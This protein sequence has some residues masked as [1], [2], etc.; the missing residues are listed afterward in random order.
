MFCAP[1]CSDCPDS[2]ATDAIP[3]RRNLLPAC[4]LGEEGRPFTAEGMHLYSVT[5]TFPGPLP[6]PDPQSEAAEFAE[7][8]LV[9]T[10]EIVGPLTCACAQQ[11][12]RFWAGRSGHAWLCYDVDDP[13]LDGAF[14]QPTAARYRNRIRAVLMQ[15]GYP[16][17]DLPDHALPRG[18]THVTSVSVALGEIRDM[19]LCTEVRVTANRCGG[20]WIAAHRAC[21]GAGGCGLT[22]HPSLAARSCGHEGFCRRHNDNT[23]PFCHCPGGCSEGEWLLRSCPN[24]CNFRGSCYKARGAC[25]RLVPRSA[26]CSL[27][28]TSPQSQCP[29]STHAYAAAQGLLH[30]HGSYAP[31]GPRPPRAC[32]CAR[33]ATGASTAPCGG[34]V[35]E[36]RGAR[37]WTSTTTSVV[38]P[39]CPRACAGRRARMPATPSA[40]RSILGRLPFTWWTS[41]RSSV[42]SRTSGS[43]GTGGRMCC[44]TPGVS[45]T[46]GRPI[47]SSSRRAW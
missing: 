1:C 4:S 23:P 31:S 17:V 16:V 28:P 12:G 42:P 27:A 32:A 21:V 10:V 24:Q 40:T 44:R 35:P 29:S 14:A 45:G 46:P 18:G 39:S 7:T 9:R 20:W 11:L 36:T 37:S 47:T 25:L 19:S 15:E 30:Y 13:T 6:D 38:T 8:G 22:A 33:R 5:V 26:R 34:R 3:R 41:R 2:C 43:T